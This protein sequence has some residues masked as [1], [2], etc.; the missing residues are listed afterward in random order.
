VPIAAVDD[1]NFIPALKGNINLPA[2]L[3]QT[4]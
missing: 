1:P 3:K 4:I 2:Y